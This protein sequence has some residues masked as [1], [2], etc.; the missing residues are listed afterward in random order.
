MT[1]YERSDRLGGQLLAAGSPAFKWPIKKF[2]DYLIA[3]NGQARHRSEAQTEALHRRQSEA[4]D[5]D[6]VLA[7]VG[8]RSM[9]HRFPASTP[10]M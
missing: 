3:K 5:Y 6:V 9:V 1:L 2:T 4:E 7:C 8:A 10:V